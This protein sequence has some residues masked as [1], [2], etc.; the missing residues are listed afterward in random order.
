ME[1]DNIIHPCTS[2]YNVKAAANEHQNILNDCE[3]VTDDESSMVIKKLNKQQKL[4]L[5]SGSLS[6]KYPTCN[7]EDNHDMLT[8]SVC[9]SKFHYQCTALPPYQIAC[10][11]L[12]NYLARK[13]Q[14]TYLRDADQKIA[15]IWNLRGAIKY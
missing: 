12:N 2:E 10:F 15:N 11:I 14:M 1:S 8:C 5:E 7:K 4:E 6:C 13:F 9:K 3:K